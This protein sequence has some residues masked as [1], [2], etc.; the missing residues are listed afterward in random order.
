M[1]IF[2]RVSRKRKCFATIDWETNYWVM[3]FGDL[4][5]KDDIGIEFTPHQLER[6]KDLLNDMGSLKG[7]YGH[8]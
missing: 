7:H 3:S 2:L 6:L 8:C 5:A 1:R 4:K